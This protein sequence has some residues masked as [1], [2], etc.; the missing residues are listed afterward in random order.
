[1]DT[2]IIKVSEQNEITS[3]VAEK[4]KQLHVVTMKFEK[5][6]NFDTKLT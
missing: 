3:Y 5:Y 2:S 4:K 6:I 1:M